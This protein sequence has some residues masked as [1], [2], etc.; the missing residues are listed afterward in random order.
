MTSPSSKG[1]GAAITFL[2]ALLADAPATCVTWPM[3]RDPNGYGRLG[4][5]G[6]HYWAHRLMCEM[7]HGPQPSPD[8]EAA[9]SC[10]NGKHGC[11]NPRHLSWATR[12]RN[13]RDRADHGTKARGGY[14]RPSRRKLTLQQVEE[15]RALKGQVTQ[16]ELA[17]RYDVT[18]AT[19]RDIYSG[20]SWT[21]PMP[22]RELTA[23][24]VIEVR[25]LHGV[26]STVKIAE[27]FGVGRGSIGRILR[28]ESYKDV[29]SGDA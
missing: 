16:R 6:G 24:E 21:S 19:I 4:H 20:K 25:A 5:E 10:G 7:A 22:W 8:H 12:N 14:R 11:V 13:Q 15:I 23:A 18:D 26:M 29:P 3:C 17:T 2:R 1:K 28:G 27:R 9:H